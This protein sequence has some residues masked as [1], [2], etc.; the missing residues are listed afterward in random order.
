MLTNRIYI[1]LADHFHTIF[2]Q[3]IPLLTP[4]NRNEAR[5]FVT[6][7]DAL[8]ER[9][10]N[11]ICTAA[12]AAGELYPAGDGSFEFARTTSRRVEMQSERYL[13]STHRNIKIVE[14]HYAQV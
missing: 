8:Y 5:R 3:D 11:L 9:K 1:T 2:I 4:E 10:V 13:A 7:I 12:A 6:L 14:P